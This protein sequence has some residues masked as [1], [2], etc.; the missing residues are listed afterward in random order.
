MTKQSPKP[1]DL[2]ARAAAIVNGATSD[3]DA[4]MQPEKDPRAVVHG[5]QG[6]TTRAFR[7]TAQRRREIAQEAIKARWAA[8]ERKKGV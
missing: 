4:A 5:R 8:A 1:Q 2:N 6:R 7:L 3:E